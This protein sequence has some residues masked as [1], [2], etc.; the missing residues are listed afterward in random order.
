MHVSPWPC[1]ISPWSPQWGYF[2]LSWLFCWLGLEQPVLGLDTCHW[3]SG[4]SSECCCSPSPSQD[5]SSPAQFNFP[6]FPM[7][8]LCPPPKK[9]FSAGLSVALT[10]VSGDTA[11]GD[12]WAQRWRCGHR[13]STNRKNALQHIFDTGARGDILL[14]ASGLGSKYLGWGVT[15]SLWAQS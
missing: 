3:G 2:S 10:T 8:S 4:Y 9:N 15:V 14:P 6:S 11:G 7:S 1:P 13:P 5:H 12:S